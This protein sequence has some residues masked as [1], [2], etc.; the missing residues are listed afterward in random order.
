I[1]DEAAKKIESQLPELGKA[2]F[3]KVFAKKSAHRLYK[4]FRQSKDD[5]KIITITSHHPEILSLPWELLHDSKGRNFV[6]AEKISIQRR[7]NSENHLPTNPKHQLHVLFIISRPTDTDFVDPRI[8]AQA[9]LDSLQDISQQITLEFLRPAT[10][11][12]LQE[13]LQD[14]ILPHIDVVHFDGYTAFQG[15]LEPQTESLPTSSY[16][17]FEQED[18]KTHAVPAEPFA[19]LLNQHRINLV[20]LSAA[21]NKIADM[22]SVAVNLINSGIPFVLSMSYS[23]LQSAAQKLFTAFYTSLASGHRVGDAVDNVRFTLYN[24]S[25]RRNL[26]RLNKLA[27]IELYD[28]FVPVLYHHGYDAPLMLP[29]QSMPKKAR[30]KR[31]NLPCSSKSK[32]FGHRRDLWNLERKIGNGMRRINIHGSKGQGKT[33]LAQEAG[34]WMNDTSRFASVVYVDYANIQ[35]I[36]PITM[37]ISTIANVLQKNLTDIDGVTQA[38]K[39][40]PTLIIFDN[41]EALGGIINEQDALIFQEESEPLIL[42][43]QDGTETFF[44]N[45]E[46]VAK[47][48]DGSQ[49]EKIVVEEE[50][51][52][53]T[54]FH[55]SF[56]EDEKIATKTATEQDTKT[57][58]EK[59]K[60]KGNKKSKSDRKKSV[61]KKAAPLDDLL[62]VAKKW[63]DAGQSCVVIISSHPQSHPKFMDNWRLDRLEPIEAIRYFDTVMVKPPRHNMP[64]RQMLEQLFGQVNY[65]PLSVGILTYRLKQD[66]I[67]SLN[68]RL[69]TELHRLP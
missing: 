12:Q 57:D 14:Q 61:K 16:L 32:S 44:F 41:V 20:I 68:E 54:E 4:K 7:I 37:A 48:S 58:T 15:G 49:I 52:K 6:I 60:N 51:E 1:D 13:R 34:R 18:G 29:E 31:T 35:N 63:S 22:N 24:E 43:E 25:E 38:L 3:N 21:T 30:S 46:P 17:L 9:M 10:L 8:N 11:Q 69:V 50:Y 26:I 33:C 65:H 59:D 5:K 23:L 19:K 67:N 62:N 55:F 64:R 45:D 53:T 2:L 47:L 39:R 66:D 27:K 56:T 40:T 42:Q 28:W 36:E